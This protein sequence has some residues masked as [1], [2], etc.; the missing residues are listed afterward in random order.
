MQGSVG[1]CNCGYIMFS[2]RSGTNQHK[3]K[4]VDSHHKERI[5]DDAELI[6]HQA[7]H[8]LTELSTEEILEALDILE[9]VNSGKVDENINTLT[10]KEVPIIFIRNFYLIL[11]KPNSKVQAS[12]VAD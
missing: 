11:L 2:K 7:D 5:M 12:A 10:D 8:L 9:R 1:S 4:M 6:K 3:E